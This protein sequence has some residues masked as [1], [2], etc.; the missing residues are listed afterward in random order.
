MSAAD[1]LCGLDDIT[2]VTAP[3]CL[4]DGRC[5]HVAVSTF[6]RIGPGATSADIDGAITD[7]LA[8]ARG[9]I[10]TDRARAHLVIDRTGERTTISAMIGGDDV[11]G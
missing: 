4:S 3:D 2:T 11:R 1:C 6:R 8:G 7:I 5:R 9:I 10:G